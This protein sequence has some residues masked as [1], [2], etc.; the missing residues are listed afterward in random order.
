ML[1]RTLKIALVGL[2]LSGTV[3]A[4]AAPRAESPSG[5]TAAAPR[6][7]RR[8]PPQIDGCFVPPPQPVAVAPC[9][10]AGSAR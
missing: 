8:R 7:P 5:R 6:P 4:T 9:D 10:D 3:A 1:T 2:T